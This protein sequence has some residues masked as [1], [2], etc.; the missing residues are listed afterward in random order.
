[1]SLNSDIDSLS[2]MVNM[3]CQHAKIDATVDSLTKWVSSLEDK[4]EASTVQIERLQDVIE[5]QSK[6][7]IASNAVLNDMKAQIDYKRRVE[8][9]TAANRELALV[10]SAKL[11]KS[12]A[13]RTGRPI[14]LPGTIH[15]DV[16]QFLNGLDH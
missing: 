5:A 2:E 15:P 4:V 6:L 14:P 10:L 3:C 7:L 8:V 16:E 9:L 13:K 12:D 1:M 11:F